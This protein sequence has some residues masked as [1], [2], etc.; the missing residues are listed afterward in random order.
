MKKYHFCTF[1]SIDGIPGVCR[2]GNDTPTAGF[3]FPVY[4]TFMN[5]PD[6]LL[7]GVRN[8][9]LPGQ[10][11][12]ALIIPTRKQLTPR[13]EDPLSRSDSICIVLSEEFSIQANG[14]LNVL[15][16]AADVFALFQADIPEPDSGGMVHFNTPAGINWSGITIKFIDGHTVSIRTT[17]SH[18]QYNYTRMGMANTRNGNPTVH[19]TLLK[20]FAENR[21]EIDKNSRKETPYHLLKKRKQDLSKKPRQFF[22]LIE[23]MRMH[24]MNKVKPSAKQVSMYLEQWDS[25]EDYVLQESSLRKLFTQTYPLNVEMDDVL[26]KVCSLNDFYSTHIFSPFTVARHIVDLDIDKRL[27][28]RDLTLVNDIALVKVNDWRTRNFYSFAT[29]YCSHHFPEHYPIYD[30]FVEKMLMHFKRVDKFCI[31][32]KKTT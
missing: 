25:L 13:T 2:L 16:S 11:P 22:R 32:S 3:N 5:D 19:W 24:S 7:E 31:N 27:A 10:D 21:G 17:K 1:N 26:I 18:G 20:D 30:R 9:S 15:R 14:S 28:N 23:E 4:L 12:Y 29:K 8:I 6:E